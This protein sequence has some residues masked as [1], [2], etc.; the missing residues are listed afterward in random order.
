VTIEQTARRFQWFAADVERVPMYQR[1]VLAASEDE[2]VMALMEEA[3]DRQRRPNLLLAAV[4]DLL[5]AGD[6]DALARW[7]PT[8]NG[9]EPPPAADVY[10]A[11]RSFVDS[12]RAAIVDMLRTRSTQTN[13]SNR[14]C[15]WRAALPAVGATVDA[16]IALLELGASAGLN[17]CFDRYTYDFDGGSAGALMQ[18]TIRSGAPPV[19]RPI[20]EIAARAGL[21]L[22]PIDV[23][24]DVQVRWLKAC[25]WPE[26]LERH[27]RFDSAVAIAREDPPRIE[28][29]DLV[30]DLGSVVATLPVDAHL[31]VVNSWVL[32]YLDRDRRVGLESRLGAIGAD[33]PVTWL[34]AEAPTVVA[35]AG[36][37]VHDA[38][39]FSAVGVARWRDGSLSRQLLAK[40]HAHLEWMEWIGL[41]PD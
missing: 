39:F 35:W 32:T 19:D 18:C 14:S 40:V 16:P 28:P 7:Y 8:V 34:T 22:H 21:D 15:L 10:P 27:R 1:I 13:E 6:D 41:S 11:F 26:H 37:L 5:L 23:R 29:G 20:P 38:E 24:D 2:E 17:L 25:V 4:H 3:P 9:G 33:R 36:E 12:H 30:D 31:V